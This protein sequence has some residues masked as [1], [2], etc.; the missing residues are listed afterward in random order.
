MQMKFLLAVPLLK[1]QKL[2]SVASR[3]FSNPT[4]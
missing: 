3:P 1:R 4:P 2:T